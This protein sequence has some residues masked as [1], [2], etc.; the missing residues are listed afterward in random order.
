TMMPGVVAEAMFLTHP[1]EA[2]LAG[3]EDVR[4]QLSKAYAAAIKEFLTGDRSN[5]APRGT[6]DGSGQALYASASRS[7][8]L[9]IAA[10]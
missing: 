1:V 10:L 9:V 5:A 2:R 4:D 7:A 8:A 3:R 6:G